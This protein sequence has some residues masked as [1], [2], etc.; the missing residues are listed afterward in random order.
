MTTGKKKLVTPLSDVPYVFN[1]TLKQKRKDSP[2]SIKKKNC[3]NRKICSRRSQ[4]D[5]GEEGGGK[6]GI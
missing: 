2:G 4:S 6:V 5:P 1:D 3:K